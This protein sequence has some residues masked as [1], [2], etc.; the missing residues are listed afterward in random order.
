MLHIWCRTYIDGVIKSLETSQ[1]GV[2]SLQSHPIHRSSPSILMIWTSVVQ[3]NIHT[4][5]P[6][7]LTVSVTHYTHSRTHCHTASMR[8]PPAAI[9]LRPLDS[10]TAT[11][12][13]A[14]LLCG[15]QCCQMEYRKFLEIWGQNISRNEKKSEDSHF[16]YGILPVVF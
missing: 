8:V 2:V 3:P 10:L 5:R 9:N 1:G 4:H 12:N 15:Q 7:V 14:P 6:S 11:I 16:H 13:Q